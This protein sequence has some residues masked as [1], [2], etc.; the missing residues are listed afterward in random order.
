METRRGHKSMRV[1]FIAAIGVCT[2]ILAGCGGGDGS[3][4]ASNAISTRQVTS[5]PSGSEAL[6]L[7]VNS[8]SATKAGKGAIVSNVTPLVGATYE[9]RK[10]V[11]NQMVLKGV[12]RGNEVIHLAAVLPGDVVT[13]SIT[14]PDAPNGKSAYGTDANTLGL[15]STTME[16][17][18]LVRT[19]VNYVAG[20]WDGTGVTC[21]N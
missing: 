12:I 10:V 6:E 15:L 14:P 13:I 3:T 9:M 21:G 19:T 7:V 11:G 5:V 4:C 2:T 1:T 16:P 18:R 8:V 17:G 20:G